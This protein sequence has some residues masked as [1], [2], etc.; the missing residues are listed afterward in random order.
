MLQWVGDKQFPVWASFPLDVSPSRFLFEYISNP[1]KQSRWIISFVF[2]L[3]TL[4]L[5]P[6]QLFDPEQDANS[7]IVEETSPVAYVNGK[8]ALFEVSSSK[9]TVYDQVN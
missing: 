9:I 8:H 5:I 2:F 7:Q 4:M 1:N 3:P 6:T